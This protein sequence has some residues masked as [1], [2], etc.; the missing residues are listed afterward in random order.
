MNRED[1]IMLRTYNQVTQEEHEQYEA[2]YDLFISWENV[3]REEIEKLLSYF[4]LKSYLC[5]SKII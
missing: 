1:A 2:M 3:P 4:V 5:E